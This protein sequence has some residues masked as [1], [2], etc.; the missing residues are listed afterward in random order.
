M[1]FY[2]NNADD[3]WLLNVCTPYCTEY[4]G[5]QLPSYQTIPPVTLL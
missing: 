5:E 2:R 3:G 1:L 4:M